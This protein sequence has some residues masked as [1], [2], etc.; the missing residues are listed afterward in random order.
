M[1]TVD[2]IV[3]AAAQLGPKQFLTLR[4]KLDRL[5]RKIWATELKSA[6]AKMARNQ[7]GDKEI[8][9]MVMRRRSSLIP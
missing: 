6:T 8:D 5:E 1:S 3:I 4:R 9:D 7:I 2:E